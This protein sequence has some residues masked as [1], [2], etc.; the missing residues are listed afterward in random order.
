MKKLKKIVWQSLN[1]MQLGG[2]VQLIL[3]S[4]LNDYGWFR[5][6]HTK[7]SVDKNG[8]PIP[9]CTYPFVHFIEGRLHKRMDIFEYG[10][11]NS[12]LWYAARVNTIKAVEHDKNWVQLMHAKLPQNAQVVFRPLEEDN[13]YEREVSQSGKKYHL[14]IIDGR[15][16]RRSSEEAIK[17]LTIDGVIIWDN[18]NVP[19]YQEGVNNLLKAGFRKLDFYGLAPIAAHLSC[20]TIFYKSNNCLGI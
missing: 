6:F 9:W 18:T 7:Q 12:T 19:H 11:G 13:A 3:Q 15:R 8:K 2:A 17:N 5:S 20:T 1:S 14:I 16:R 4:A 10:C